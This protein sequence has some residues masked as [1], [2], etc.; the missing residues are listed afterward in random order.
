LWD[1]NNIEAILGYRQPIKKIHQYLVRWR[2]GSVADD[3]W[4]KG[5]DFAA[6]LH[7]YMYKFHDNFG[8]GKLILSPEKIV[9]IP[10]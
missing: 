4:I 5:S 3:S 7:P 6:V 2:G 8:G 10:Y 9:W 1:E